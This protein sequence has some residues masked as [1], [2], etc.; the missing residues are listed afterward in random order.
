[1]GWPETYLNCWFNW[2]HRN[3]GKWT[4]IGRMEVFNLHRLILDVLIISEMLTFY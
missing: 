4:K 3:T 1:M 2:L